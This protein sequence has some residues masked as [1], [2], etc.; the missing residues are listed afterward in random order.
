MLGDVWC[1]E[2]PWF[3]H[4]YVALRRRTRKALEEG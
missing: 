2:F 4:Q 1:D 3:L